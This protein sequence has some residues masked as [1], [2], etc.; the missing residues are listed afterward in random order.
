MRMHVAPPHAPRSTEGGGF[1][2]APSSSSSPSARMELKS[3]GTEGYDELVATLSTAEARSEVLYG[4]FSCKVGKQRKF[5]F[6]A[7]IGESCSG[8]RR[9]KVS[10]HKQGVSNFFEGVCAS[11]HVTDLDGLEPA[12]IVGAIQVC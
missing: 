4:A 2:A 1:G 8:M 6:L 11:V 5:V 10:M 9:A 3:T 12:A 7:F